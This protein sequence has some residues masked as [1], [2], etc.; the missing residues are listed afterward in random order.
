MEET[1]IL[2]TRRYPKCYFN[3]KYVYYVKFSSVIL[4]YFVLYI[5]YLLVIE[6]QYLLT[7]L[8]R[9]RES[10]PCMY[11]RLYLRQTKYMFFF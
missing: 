8:I 7:I 6:E 1:L 2:N 10:Q 4:F 11:N 3:N 5:S 9:K